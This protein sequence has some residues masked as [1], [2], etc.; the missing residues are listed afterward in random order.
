MRN[1]LIQVDSMTKY[2][3][4]TCPDCGTQVDKSSPNM[5][6]CKPCALKAHGETKTGYADKV[7]TVCGVTFKPTGSVQK[8]CSGCRDGYRTQM[9]RSHL[10]KL[11]REA[12]KT[13]VGTILMCDTCGDDFEY[14]SGPQK[15][16]GEC[17]RKLEV[18]RMRE[19]LE[20][21]KE[22]LRAYTQRA[23]DNYMFGGN[24]QAALERD[25]FTCQ[26][27]GATSDLHVHHIDGNGVTSARETRNNAIDN[28]VTLCRGCHTK[29]HHRIRHSS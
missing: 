28:L 4:L 27:C 12:G 17:Q 26:H 19:W 18:S 20:S 22:R 24:R 15:R 9:N 21:D 2:G 10:A 16:C 5:R 29:E 11:R 25:K 13:P 14:L 1:H 8:V 23:K 7:C 6:R 3:L